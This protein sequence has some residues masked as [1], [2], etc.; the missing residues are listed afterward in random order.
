MIRFVISYQ[1]LWSLNLLTPKYNLEYAGRY[2]YPFTGLQYSP[3]CSQ[4]LEVWILYYS[5][6]RPEPDTSNLRS[7]VF[8]TRFNNQAGARAVIHASQNWAFFPY[9]IPTD[10]FTTSTITCGGTHSTTSNI[11]MVPSNVWIDR[12]I[13][14]W[15]KPTN[16]PVQRIH[17][18]HAGAW[19]FASTDSL[20]H[21]RV[22][23]WLRLYNDHSS[24]WIFLCR[25]YVIHVR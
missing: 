12:S 6:R 7:C 23:I 20:V 1:H 19:Y 22:H 17:T 4:I 11:E 5:R 9:D 18:V 8:Y 24:M 16:T 14:K 13:H 10:P 2:W 3:T 15:D 25:W 21:V